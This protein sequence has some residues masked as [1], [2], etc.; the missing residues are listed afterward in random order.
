MGISMWRAGPKAVDSWP[1]SVDSD[2]WQEKSL[3]V[4][5]ILTQKESFSSRDSCVSVLDDEVAT[6]YWAI[7]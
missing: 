4:E 2:R 7:L 6:W 1:L 3:V 5:K